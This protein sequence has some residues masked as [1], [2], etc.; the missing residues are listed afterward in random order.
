LKSE[1]RKQENYFYTEF[2]G[3]DHKPIARMLFDHSVDPL[4]L[5]NLAEKEIHQ[6]KVE[7]LAAM[8]RQNWGNDFFVNRR[9]KN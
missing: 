7:E 2:L 5:D 1:W 9:E 6:E 4:E 8:L 3:I